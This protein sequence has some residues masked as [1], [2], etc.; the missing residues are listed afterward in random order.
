LVH[1]ANNLEFRSLPGAA[2]DRLPGPKLQFGLYH[3]TLITAC[4]IVACYRTGYLS[5]FRDRDADRVDVDRVDVAPDSLLLPEMYHY[6][7]DDPKTT[8]LYPIFRDFRNWSFPHQ[9]LPP[10]WSGTPST[11]NQNYPR[12]PPQLDRIESKN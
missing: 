2:C 8:E 7:L 3:E 6:N 12:A 4:I 11:E 9:Q 1:P 5:K 10:S